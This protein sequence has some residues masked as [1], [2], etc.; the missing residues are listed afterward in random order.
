M[1]SGIICERNM[2][3]GIICERNMDSG[4]ICERSSGNLL[5]FS[6]SSD[7]SQKTSRFY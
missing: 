5:S 1:D 3:S 4:I 2:D 7:E 6:S